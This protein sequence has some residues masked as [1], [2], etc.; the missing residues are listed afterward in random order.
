MPSCERNGN[1]QVAKSSPAWVSAV[2]QGD[3]LFL[4]ASSTSLAI[5]RQLKERNDLTVITYSLEVLHELAASPQIDIILLGGV[6]QRATMSLIGP[7]GLEQ[8]RQVNIRWG[9]F[10]AHG[11]EIQT[12]LTDISSA[13][14]SVKRE[15]HPLCHEVIAVI[16]STKWGRVGPATFAALSQVQRIISD[17]GVPAPLVAHLKQQGI[18]VTLV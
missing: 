17:I 7:Y 14:A 2:E 5:A 8:L 11:L 16:D 15:L 6:F 10:G 3:A 12:G 13:E 4:D 18:Q 9:F 1:N